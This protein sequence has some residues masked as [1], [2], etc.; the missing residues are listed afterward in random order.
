MQNIVNTINR[1]HFCSD[2][3][4]RVKRGYNIEIDGWI[5]HPDKNLR[6][7]MLYINSRFV[8]TQDFFVLHSVLVAELMHW[9]ASDD[10]NCV[11]EVLKQQ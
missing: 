10:V 3:H 6:C 5:D 1:K 8:H 4:C 7:P 2:V 11:T 9:Q